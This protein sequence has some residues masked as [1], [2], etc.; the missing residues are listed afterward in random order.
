[1]EGVFLGVMDIN[2]ARTHQQKLKDLGVTVEFRTNGHTCTTG[3]TVTVEVWGKEE[4]H[5]K[6]THYFHHDFLK[7]VRGHAPDLN[8]LSEVFDP[9]FETV[10]CQACGTKFRPNLAECPDC[11]LNYSVE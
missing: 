7:H 5:E 10:I 1:M 3:C 2:E 8:T 4:D 6:L 11:G 9:S